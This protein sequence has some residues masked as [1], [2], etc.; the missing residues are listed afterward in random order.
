MS[1]APSFCLTVIAWGRILPTVK[2]EGHWLEL[3]G[4]CPACRR[5]Q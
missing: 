2:V 5:K 3:F 4:L 1:G